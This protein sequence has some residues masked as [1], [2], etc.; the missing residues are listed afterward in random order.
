MLLRFLQYL[1]IGNTPTDM[2]GRLDFF[3]L[4]EV[5]EL[6]LQ[7]FLSRI[8]RPVPDLVPHFLLQED[9]LQAAAVH[10]LGKNMEENE[11]CLILL[12]YIQSLRQSP[13]RM[14]RT[15]ASMLLALVIIAAGATYGHGQGMMG[16]YGYGPGYGMGPGMMGGYGEGGVYCPHCGSYLGPRGGY[17][18]GRGMMGGYGYGP[19]P[20]AY[21]RV[22]N[23]DCQKFLNETSE[24]RRDLH[25]KRYE[26]FEALRDP[27]TTPE[28]LA[29]KEKELRDMQE[30]I[31]AKNPQGCWW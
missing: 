14:S 30:K 21:G 8:R 23:E 16:G 10:V 5:G 2:R 19:G 7:A 20:R 11:L 4:R 25:N 22:P 9:Q 17:G 18:M 15:I 28:S 27:K 3:R 13:V 6:L 29:K 1:V 26:Y 12:R 31:Y 24:L